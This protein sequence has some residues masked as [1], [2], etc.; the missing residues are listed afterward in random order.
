MRDF[1]DILLNF[2]LLILLGI[3]FEIH[4]VRV[5]SIHGGEWFAAFSYAVL[6]SNYR[7]TEP[8]HT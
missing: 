8:L 5:D 1:H 3:V 2:D 7:R 6:P 4:N